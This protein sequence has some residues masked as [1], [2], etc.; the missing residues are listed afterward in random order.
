M[1]AGPVLSPIKAAILRAFC[2]NLI[3]SAYAARAPLHRLRKTTTIHGFIGL[4]RWLEKLAGGFYNLTVSSAKKESA[5][6]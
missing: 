5:E 6:G 3:A 2:Q 4:V 1:I